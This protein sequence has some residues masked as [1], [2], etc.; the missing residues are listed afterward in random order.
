MNKQWLYGKDLLIL[1]IRIF[2]ILDYEVSVFHDR[3]SNYLG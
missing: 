1:T 2:I 3:H